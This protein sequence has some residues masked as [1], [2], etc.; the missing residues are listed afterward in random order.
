MTTIFID[1]TETTQWP[2]L[3]TANW[4]KLLEI[5]EQ[6]NINI[7]IPEVVVKETLRKWKSKYDGNLVKLNSLQHTIRTDGNDLDWNPQDPSSQNREA[8]RTR[9][10]PI[11]QDDNI[12]PLL[13]QE[14]FEQ[15]LESL[16]IKVAPLPKTPIGDIL[17][18]ELENKKPFVTNSKGFSKG[19][20]D[21]LIWETIK[22][23]LSSGVDVG[24]FYFVSSNKTDF[25]NKEG[26]AIHP[27]LLKELQHEGFANVKW[28]SDLKNL[29]EIIKSIKSDATSSTK[30]IDN[31]KEQHNNKEET[32]EDFYIPYIEGAN[33]KILQQEINLPDKEYPEGIDIEN[34]YLPPAIE[35]AYID[36]IEINS[37]SLEINIHEE[38]EE[39]DVLADINIEASITFS[40][41]IHK[42]DQYMISSQEREEYDLY[43][44]DADHNRHYAE[45]S[46][47]FEARI[48]YQIYEN[49]SQK[50]VNSIYLHNIIRV[51]NQ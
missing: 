35:T 19:F 38:F 2:G 49:P 3:K 27:T 17:S 6:K 22:E 11:S 28:L 4:R 18:R 8:S 32:L 24:P 33:H 29:F 15:Y 20:R 43:C 25:A 34:L 47:Q 39:D 1:S 12:P 51:E 7:V 44:T 31:T 45:F 42:A 10:L 40:A 41:Y 30:H 48:Q 16:H 36:N 9:N 13:H 21:T 14:I 5:S 23:Y 46:G 26:T 37:D 50:I